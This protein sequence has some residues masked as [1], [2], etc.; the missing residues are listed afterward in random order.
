MAPGANVEAFACACSDDRAHPPMIPRGEHQI[1]VY[2]DGNRQMSMAHHRPSFRAGTAT[3]SG[4][5][6]PMR[7]AM[8]ISWATGTPIRYLLCSCH[9]WDIRSLGRIEFL[10]DMA[11]ERRVTLSG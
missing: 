5:W 10:I 8:S 1:I 2:N 3:I 11:T 6:M 9:P 4:R 7:L